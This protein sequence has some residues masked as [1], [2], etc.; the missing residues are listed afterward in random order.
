[1]VLFYAGF[2]MGLMASGIFNLIKYVMIKESQ[3]LEKHPDY[4]D[5]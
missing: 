2:V 5:E 1:M 4:F 3:F